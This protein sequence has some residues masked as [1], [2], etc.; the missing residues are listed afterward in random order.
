MSPLSRVLSAAAV[1]ACALLIGATGANA[2]TT[3]CNGNHYLL[4]DGHGSPSVSN[5]VAVGLPRL[6]DGYA[7]GCLVAEALAGDVQQFH[8]L[9][10]RY[11]KSL[12]TYG[13]QWD[14]GVWKFSYV[15]RTAGSKRYQHATARHGARRVTIDFGR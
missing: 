9:H 15:T 13:A 6:T 4:I 1:A 7:P 5:I 8:R 10:H 2:Q 3:R 12:H 11:P 14:G